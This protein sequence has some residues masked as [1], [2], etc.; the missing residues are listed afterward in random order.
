MD[1]SKL[2]KTVQ[3]A[4]LNKVF[5]IFTLTRKY[6]IYCHTERGRAVK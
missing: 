1:F 2:H 6:G 4:N 3:K 5:D